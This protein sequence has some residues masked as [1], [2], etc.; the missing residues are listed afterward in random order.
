MNML[1]PADRLLLSK[2]LGLLGSDKEGEAQAAGRAAH[3][4][5]QQRGLS[6]SQ[7]LGEPPTPKRE[8]ER[9]TWRRTCRELQQRSGDLRQWEVKFVFDLP[10]FSRISTKQRYTLTCIAERVLRRDNNVG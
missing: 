3:R 5:L 6:W 1:S 9:G 7:V 8:P 10:N 2:I 4:L